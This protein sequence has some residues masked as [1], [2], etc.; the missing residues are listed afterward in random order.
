MINGALPNSGGKA[1]PLTSALTIPAKIEKMMDRRLS[2]PPIS[3]A[4]P[5]STAPNITR[6][7][8]PIS[9]FP[10]ACVRATPSSGREGWIN[11]VED[12]VKFL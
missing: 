2:D 12:Y 3:P 5:P 1:R 11:I 10:R 6:N 8:I 4:S 7:I 9:G